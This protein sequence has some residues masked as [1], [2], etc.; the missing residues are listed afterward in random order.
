MGVTV[1]AL[2][3]WAGH[4][5]GKSC[6]AVILGSCA[7]ACLTFLCLLFL[8]LADHIKPAK[9]IRIGRR[10]ADTA[11]PLALADDLKAGI[12]TAE[13]LMV[14]K[15][16]AL[17]AGAA[18]P[19]AL[20]GTV[21]GM[22][23]PVLMF[24]AAI[25]FGL[26]EL[27]IPELARCSAAGSTRRIH[28]LVR[29]SLRVAML[30]GC[31]FCGLLFLLSE[32]LCMVL[33]GSENAGRYLRWFAL[34]AP[35]LYCDAITDAMVKGL[36]QQKTSVRY[37]IFTS[38][39]DVVFLYILL[40]RYGIGGYFVSFL[41]THLINFI[42]SLRLLLKITVQR[43]PAYVPMLCVSAVGAGILLS[44]PLSGSAIRAAA[45]LAIFISLLTLFRI[46]SKEDILWIK[47]LIN[48]K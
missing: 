34:L 8:R 16:L 36:G 17:F 14:P 27:L 18:D 41:V 26:A 39:L 22:V 43:L 38:V 12:N 28:Y 37:N 48:K 13:N 11:I 2:T 40:P 46:L 15:R 23:F 35:M 42:L 25:L 19:L 45:F 7:G 44:S 31:V 47:G 3:L 5:P 30:Y 6:Q 4:D 21:S 33:Y 32:D 1:S 10:L 24:P 29:R 20:F 9:K